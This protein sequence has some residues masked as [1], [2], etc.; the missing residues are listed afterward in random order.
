MTCRTPSKALKKVIEL[1]PEPP[2][3]SAIYTMMGMVHARARNQD[4]AI[5]AFQE[6]IK[7]NNKPRL[8]TPL[9]RHG[10]HAIE[11]I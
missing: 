6:A 9:P 3:P 11:Q 10:A 8:C 4:A 7:L 2:F 1:R 5:K